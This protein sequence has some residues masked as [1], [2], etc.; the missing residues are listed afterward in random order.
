[1]TT[2]SF[3]LPEEGSSNNACK[4]R[5]NSLIQLILI[6]YR[7]FI[8]EPG[9]LFWSIIFPVL[10]AWVLGIAFSKQ[11]G[12][13]QQVA[14]IDDS[15]NMNPELRQFLHD[16]KNVDNSEKN[17]EVYL[18]KTIQNEKLGKTTF[19][20][21]MTDWD[22]G[23]LLLKRGQVNLILREYPDSVEYFFDPLNPQAKMVYILLSSAI[24]NENLVYES[25]SINPLTQK[26]NRYIDFLIPGLVAMGVMNSLLW[27]ISYA[28]IEMRSKKLLRRMVATPMKR[29]EFLI[30]IF[31]ARLSI[32]IIEALLLLSF[33]F[34]YFHIS[35]QGSLPALILIF[36]AGNIAFSGIAILISSRTANSRIGTGLINVITMPMTVLSGIFFSYHNFPDFA[37]PIIQKFPLTMMAD[38]I[39]SVFI[40]GAGIAQVSL[41]ALILSALGLI[42][43]AVGLRTYKWY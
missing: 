32:T 21:L 35:I 20:F 24:N 26:G 38:S 28:L 9:I 23:L 34:V 8:R 22:G 17:G 18:E 40:E 16:A 29:S 33:A 2:C 39:R 27:G 42:C 3:R 1:L 36:L 13:A 4:M 31:V 10:M 37:V 43:F 6:H 41:N 11:A 19:K 14:F 30:S 7:E 5:R 25:A 12:L 15:S